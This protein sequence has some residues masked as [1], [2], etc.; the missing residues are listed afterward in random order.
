MFTHKPRLFLK[1][2]RSLRRTFQ[3]SP[4]VSIRWIRTKYQNEI[5]IDNDPNRV[6]RPLI[7]LKAWINYCAEAL[8]G[9]QSRD[10]K[11]IRTAVDD[12][13]DD[14]E[15][16]SNIH[17]AKTPTSPIEKLVWQPNVWHF[18]HL[19][20][21]GV[22]EYLDQGEI[23][24]LSVTPSPAYL[25]QHN[26]E[27]FTHM[28]I[29]QSHVFG[30]AGGETPA[31]HTNQSPRNVYQAAMIKQAL[32]LFIDMYRV[33]GTNYRLFYAQEPLYQT[34]LSGDIQRANR[35][36]GI[37]INLL[38]MSDKSNQEDA[39]KAS[40]RLFQLGAYVSETQRIYQASVKK[41]VSG[42]ANE[43]FE[44]PD[45]ATTVGMKEDQFVHIDKA[46]GLPPLRTMLKSGH[47]VIGKTRIT[48]SA[49]QKRKLELAHAS[50]G[51]GGGGGGGIED[52][53]SE[54]NV[55]YHSSNK[56]Q[57]TSTTTYSVNNAE[58]DE[59]QQE[60]STSLMERYTSLSKASAEAKAIESKYYKR[61]ESVF[62]RSGE[63]GL[64]TKITSCKNKQTGSVHR[65]V[66]VRSLRYPECGDKFTMRNG[67]KG[68]VGCICKPEEMPFEI[69]TGAIAD[70]VVNPSC[71]PSRMTHNL[72]QEAIA[73]ISAQCLCKTMEGTSFTVFDKQKNENVVMTIAE[74]NPSG[75]R[76]YMDPITG[77]MIESPLFTGVIYYQKLKHM[78]KDKAHAR[79]VGAI[80]FLTRQP[81]SGRSNDGG[82][83]LGEMERD[84]MIAHGASAIL[85]ETQTTKSDGTSV[86]ICNDCGLF[87]PGNIKYA[88]TYCQY[89][90]KIT[91]SRRVVMGHTSILLLYEIMA[92]GIFV[93]LKTKTKDEDIKADRTPMRDA[94]ESH[95]N[96]LSDSSE[97]DRT[98][99]RGAQASRMN[100][101][102]YGKKCD[103]TIA[104]SDC[105][106]LSSESVKPGWRKLD[107]E[108]D[109]R[110]LSHIALKMDKLVSEMEKELPR[111]APSTQHVKEIVKPTRTRGRK[112]KNKT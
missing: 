111:L 101:D 13:D 71:M 47:A 109:L 94:Q 104:N 32:T 92:M 35:G 42:V 80:Q 3:I 68:V 58:S 38:L 69:G 88:F 96:P 82:L 66:C 83:R 11:W 31:A 36:Y 40:E 103:H 78:V 1:R 55:H 49:G 24:T 57:K 67:Q 50:R 59:N 21:Q 29:N 105:S 79:S 75:A 25:R 61:D 86:R 84:C 19:W 5:W 64:V 73:A 62:I 108:K 99:F 89:C 7:I 95:M 72:N 16:S 98:I 65:K 60:T 46:S 30:V 22:I 45:P 93:N 2:F 43:L 107:V 97:V 23:M 87:V 17:G 4:F 112:P 18:K 14:D 70:L 27:P 63:P 15:G 37:N 44:R 85:W 53:G 77:K 52:K 76:R 26:N 6:V 74:I 54:G 102:E 20:E 48:Q 81:V 28:E 9:W 106:S 34:R 56:R 41:S 110:G 39:I 91:D 90:Q 100:E 8:K 33:N 10:P 51:G 12:A